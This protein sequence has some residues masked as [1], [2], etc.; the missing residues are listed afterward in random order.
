[1]IR[2]YSTIFSLL[3]VTAIT[4]GFGLDLALPLSFL[5]LGS[6][7]FSGPLFPVVKGFS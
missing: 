4:F 6:P 5:K 2:M 3:H 1:M 7:K